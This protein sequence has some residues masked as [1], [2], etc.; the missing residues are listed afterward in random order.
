MS[1]PV[2]ING[3]T[4]QQ[5]TQGTVA[6]WGAT[7]AAI[8]VALVSACL[9]K[10]GGSFTLSAEADFGATYGLKS[11][12]FK[13]RTA[14]PGSWGSVRLA[15]NEGVVWRDASN[16][17]DKAL[18]LNA[19]NL[20]E[21]DDAEIATFLTV[22][23]A[24]YGYLSG[25]TS[26]IQTQL[27]QRVSSWTTYTPTGNWTTNATY[28]GKWRRVGNMMEIYAVITLSGSPGSSTCSLVMPGAYEVDTTWLGYTGYGGDLG[29]CSVY[30][31]GGGVTYSGATVLKTGSTTE[32][33]GR[34]YTVTGTHI[35]ATPINSTSPIGSGLNNGDLVIYNFRVP[36]VGW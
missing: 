23:K 20:L 13:S 5:P 28:T 34:A 16:A 15:N 29:S 35:D 24:E 17:T 3:V 27:D 12:Y 7:Q 19:S 30:D 1:I 9:Q 21:I 4:Y 10:T 32:F 18:R 11:S 36:V 33:Y 25:V 6:P 14:N 8:I 22:S 31:P 26:A 2:V